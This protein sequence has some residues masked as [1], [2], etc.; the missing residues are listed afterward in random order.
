MA[1]A[2]GYTAVQALR[3]ATPP[4]IMAS[5]IAAPML[6][7]RTS[8]DAE[9]VLPERVRKLLTDGD[10]LFSAKKAL[11]SFWQECALNFFPEMADFTT[12][13]YLGE[14]FADNLTTSYPLIAR[15]SLGDSIGSLLRPA[16]LD[17]TSPGVW[18]TIT[19]EDQRVAEIQ[20][21][22]RWLD[23]ATGVQRRAMYDYMSGFVRA[24]KQADHCF[25]TFG[26]AP[27]SVQTTPLTDRLVYQTWHLRD[28]VWCEDQYGNIDT[29]QRKW[30]PTASELVAVFGG[31]VSSKV[32]D[33][34]SKDPYCKIE[35]RHIVISAQNY[36][37]RDYAGKRFRQPWV[38]I[39]VD[40]DNQTVMEERGSDSR[41]Y[42]IPRWV[43]VPGSQY[44]S[45]PAVTAALP[46]ARL[47]QAMTL[48][49]LEASEKFADP[50]MA[51]TQA[52]IK[53]DIALFPGGITWVDGEYDERL[54]AALRPI[55]QPTAGQNLAAGFQVRADIREMI[56][57]AFFLDS[58]QLPPTDV[59]S[60]TA[61][62]VGQRIS[63]WIRQAMPIFEPVEFEYNAP[64]CEETFGIMLRNGA[65]G[66]VE[67]LPQVL[68]GA[69]IKFKFE[70]P[71]HQNADRQKGQKFLEAK[72]ALVQA[73]ELDP[74]V[75]PMLNASEA[76]RD[77]L[78]SIG[79]PPDW[80]RS[81]QE[82]Q[83][84]AD[85]MAQQQMAQQVLQGGLAGSQI[86]ANLGTASKAFVEAQNAPPPQ[87]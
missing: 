6:R 23:W 57:K 48:T 81:D 85:Q 60:M 67:S 65:F 7:K 25:V 12:T 34:L 18:F 59:R 32:Q 11:D 66:P 49:L 71:L 15:R 42:I 79:S 73:A 46:D 70:S 55:Y 43:T 14:E 56:F 30:K 26:Q 82:M 22:R 87:Q 68:R 37:Q 3:G 84:L 16:S 36:E 29:V 21:A 13:R 76:L 28:V 78:N 24:T 86:A 50:P 33:Q 53:S 2:S 54:G 47:I 80:V 61:F 75:T 5:G 64:L 8:P 69:D 20:E 38:S 44:A 77:V 31:K 74:Q 1:T 10:K 52:A 45:S 83:A 27:I 62:E 72:A 51:A 4:S 41:I 63:E 19:T 58:L 39:W 9:G 17:T 35:C 40:V